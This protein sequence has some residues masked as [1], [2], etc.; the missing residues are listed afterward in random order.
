MD[1]KLYIGRS[2][3]FILGIDS[4][5]QD[6]VISDP[7]AL[8]DWGVALWGP[9][10]G[11]LLTLALL[12]NHKQLVGN[13]EYLIDTQTVHGEEHVVHVHN[14]AKPHVIFPAT[15]HYYQTSNISHQSPATNTNVM[16]PCHEAPQ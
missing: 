10:G 5:S 6:A 1:R 2:D 13:S 11:W 7:H 3:A 12:N 9:S 16:T 8:Q 14:D 15:Q 4:N